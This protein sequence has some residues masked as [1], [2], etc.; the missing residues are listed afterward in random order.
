MTA[1]PRPPDDAP[2]LAG[3][4]LDEFQ[5][6]I[7]R[8]KIKGGAVEPERALTWAGVVLA[9]TGIVLA[10]VAYNGSKGASDP[11]QQTDFVVLALVGVALSL[12]GTIVWARQSLSRY[13]R[14]W[15]IRL[16]YEE[17]QQADR[18]V[19]AIERRDRAEGARSESPW[20]S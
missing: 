16:V 10:L 17:R 2:P 1:A 9:G 19:D 5:A 7:A 6:E 20:P 4:R 3:G 15:L 12:V 11:R 14:F 18:I 13:L 8:L